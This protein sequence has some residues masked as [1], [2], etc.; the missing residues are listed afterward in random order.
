MCRGEKGEGS[1]CK[2]ASLGS[3]SSQVCLLRLH[4]MV[5]SQNPKILYQQ[6]VS[7]SGDRQIA[8]VLRSFSIVPMAEWI[9]VLDASSGCITGVPCLPVPC[10]RPR[11]PTGART[12]IP[13]PTPTHLLQAHRAAPGECRQW[14]R[15]PCKCRSVLQLCSTQVA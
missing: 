4:K 11:P 14:S 10:P 15:T 3:V 6:T 5:G 2:Q 12:H 1:F 7:G 9:Y 8:K 13:I